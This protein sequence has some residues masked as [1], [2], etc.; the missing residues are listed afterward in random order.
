M[1]TQ[2]PTKAPDLDTQ[3][4]CFF[5]FFCVV[6]CVVFFLVVWVCC[7]VFFFFVFFVC[8]FFF[9]CCFGFLFGART[10]WLTRLFMIITFPI[11]YPI[12]KMLDLLLG[13]E[14]GVVYNRERLLELIKT[15]S[16]QLDEFRIVSGALE[17]TTKTV[18]DVMTRAEVDA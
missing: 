2:T 12:S 4:F 17:Y 9:F 16:H 7:R 13:D 11:S 8:F 1:T 5:F 3:S 15:S 6:F 10:I 18:K 14:V